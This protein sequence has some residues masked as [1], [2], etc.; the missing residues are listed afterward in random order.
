MTTLTTALLLDA[1]IVIVLVYCVTAGARRGFVRTFCSLIAV[2]ISLGGGWYLSTYYAEPLQ[3]KI[4]PFIMEKLLSAPVEGLQPEFTPP[5]GM[6]GDGSFLDRFSQSIQEQVEQQ[7]NNVKTAAA[8][9]IAA[10]LSSL[11]ARSVLFLAGFTVLQLLWK[12]ISRALNLV[13]KLPVLRTLN[14][15]LGGVIGFCKGILILAIAHWVLLD[16]LGLIPEAVA[17][18]SFLLPMLSALPIFSPF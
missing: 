12:T 3:E 8:E 4:E 6:S 11:L 10:S 5:A 18:S 1:V 15:F 17:Q 13:A 7:V 14:R 9:E 16:L 2:L